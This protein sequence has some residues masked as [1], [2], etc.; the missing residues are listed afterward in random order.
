M[1]S[2][3][4]RRKKTKMMLKKVEKLE[5]G[6]CIRIACEKVIENKE[7]IFWSDEG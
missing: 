1:R 6:D 4:I 7:W 2:N 5:K 3:Y